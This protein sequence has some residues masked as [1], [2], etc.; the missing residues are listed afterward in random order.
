MTQTLHLLFEYLAWDFQHGTI[1][2]VL[3]KLSRKTEGVGIVL[4]ESKNSSLCAWLS[5]IRHDDLFRGFR[6]LEALFSFS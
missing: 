4:V 2:F 1:Q 3:D 5:E 6:A